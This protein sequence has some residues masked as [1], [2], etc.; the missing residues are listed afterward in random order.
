MLHRAATDNPE[1][2]GIDVRLGA[3]IIAAIAATVVA[4]ISYIGI[5][6]TEKAAK[7]H[8]KRD[9]RIRQLGELYG[10]LYMRR[11]LTRRLWEQLPESLDP[12]PGVTPWNLVDHIEEIKLDPNDRRRLVVENILRENAEISTIITGSAGLLE[13]FPPPESFERFLEHEA[14]LRMH[15]ERGQNAIGSGRKP[16]PADMDKD[17]E[18]AIKRLRA[19]LKLPLRDS[20][21]CIIPV[22]RKVAVVGEGQ[23]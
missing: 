18:A 1:I 14:T 4:I 13:D 21:A 16:F 10:P 15:W 7:K 23:Y 11:K 3:A 9:Y 8:A 17:I 6:R 20:L 19:D 22:C 5:R 12:E 2:W